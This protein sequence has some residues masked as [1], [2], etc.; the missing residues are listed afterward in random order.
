MEH[1][2]IVQT[3]HEINSWAGPLAR[4]F[5]VPSVRPYASEKRS[6]HSQGSKRVAYSP[7]DTR[8]LPW[9]CRRKHYCLCHGYIHELCKSLQYLPWM[10]FF[11]GLVRWICSGMCLSEVPITATILMDETTQRGC[12]IISS[13]GL[14]QDQLH[15]PFNG[16]VGN[17]AWSSM[18]QIVTCGC[19]Y[20]T[21]RPFNRTQFDA[22]TNLP[23]INSWSDTLF[24]RIM[25]LLTTQK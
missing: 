16:Q 24:F 9:G 12:R 15:L 20:Q 6:I 1:H 23:N 4:F 13:N 3:K 19:L 22:T 21:F 8:I 17:T 11:D 5:R 7:L 25:P 18:C 2:S 10:L 14:S